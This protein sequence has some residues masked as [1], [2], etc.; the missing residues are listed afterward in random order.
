MFA[1]PEAY[2]NA[3]GEGRDCDCYSRETG[4]SP[5]PALRI[6]AR[7]GRC[8]GPSD[9]I[10]LH[11]GTL[12]PAVVS[13]TP[14]P[15]TWTMLIAGFVGLGFFSSR[16]SK[17]PRCYRGRLIK[18]FN[19]ISERPRGRRRAFLVP[20]HFICCGALSLYGRNAKCRNVHFKS[21]AL[22]GRLGASTFRLSTASL[23]GRLGASTFRLSTASL[24][25]RLGQA[26]SGYPPLQCR[27]RS[28]ARASLR[29]RHQGR[30]IMGPEDEAEQSFGRP[31]RHM[32]GRCK[33]TSELTSSIVPRGTSFHRRVELEFP[34]IG[35][36]PMQLSCCYCGLFPCPAELG[37]VN[38]NAVHDH[39]QSAGQRHN[40]LFH[41]ATP[42][43]L[44]RPGL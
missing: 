19:W 12:T 41:P 1:V 21:A 39:S 13:A 42:G 20:S 38:P 33:R 11:R 4:L 18:T 40:R 35:F 9:D 31:Y 15:A 32:N 6:P 5:L 14:L 22:I 36:D 10:L 34:P 2:F 37:A 7:N 43:D 16:G 29:N 24:I 25:G 26:L 30:S 17:R 27:C 23:I 28:R 8:R 44:H 3:V